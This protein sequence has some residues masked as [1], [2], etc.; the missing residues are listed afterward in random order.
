MMKSMGDSEAETA[1][2]LIQEIHQQYKESFI[3]VAIKKGV[4]RNSEKKMD[5]ASIEAMLSEACLNMKNSRALFKHSNH[6]LG[7]L[8]LSLR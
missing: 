8:F 1:K 2:Y 3:A 5:A 4:A 6:F 7:S